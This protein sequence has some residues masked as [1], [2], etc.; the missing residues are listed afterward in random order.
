MGSS[1]LF[2]PSS[3]MVLAEREDTDKEDKLGRKQ[4]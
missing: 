4:I 3:P 1:L 2:H